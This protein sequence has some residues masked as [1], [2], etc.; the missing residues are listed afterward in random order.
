[1]RTI[2]IVPSGNQL[3]GYVDI[4][5]I[6]LLITNLKGMTKVESLVKCLMTVAEWN[7][8]PIHTFE[9]VGGSAVKVFT[10]VRTIELLHRVQHSRVAVFMSL[11]ASKLG[12]FFMSGDIS[13]LNVAFMEMAS[14]EGWL[15]VVTGPYWLMVKIGKCNDKHKTSCR[16]RTLA[17]PDMDIRFF[18]VPLHLAFPAEGELKN[19]LKARDRWHLYQECFAKCHHNGILDEANAVALLFSQEGGGCSTSDSKATSVIEVRDLPMQGQNIPAGESFFRKGVKLNDLLA[20]LPAS[21]RPGP[22]YHQPAI[23]LKLGIHRYYVCTDKNITAVLPISSLKRN[24]V[25]WVPRSDARRVL[26]DRADAL[27]PI[28]IADEVDGVCLNK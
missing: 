22:G 3:A 1:M 18:D 6:L 25:I 14:Q 15:Y 16:Y 12:D 20:G 4:C 9:N 8:L 19:R 17:G 28:I 13:A 2:R 26:G 7:M 21:R 10:V 27:L 11:H 24:K 5:S 23:L